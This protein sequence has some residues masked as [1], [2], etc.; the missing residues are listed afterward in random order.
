MKLLSLAAPRLLRK[1]CGVGEA[2]ELVGIIADVQ[3]GNHRRFGGSAEGGVNARARMIL[4]VLAR[5]LD[6]A[7][8]VRCACVVVAG[9]LFD[10]ARPEAALLAAVQRLFSQARE[11]GTRIVVLRGNHDM[12]SD[13]A[14]DNAQ[15]PLAGHASVVAKPTV[16]LVERAMGD[17]VALLLLPYS[18]AQREAGWLAPAVTQLADVAGDVAPQASRLLVMHAGIVGATTPPWLASTPGAVRYEE[19]RVLMDAHAIDACVA[20][21]WHGRRV[22]ARDGATPPYYDVLQV[23]ALVPTGWDNP[24]NRGRY[25][26]IAF[27]SGHGLQWEELGGPRF[28]K[29]STRAEA[30][31]AV[32]AAWAEDRLFVQLPSLAAERDANLQWLAAALERGDIVGGEAPP[33]E[34]EAQVE[35]RAAAGSARAAETFDAALAG[36]VGEMTVDDGVQRERIIDRCRGYLAGGGG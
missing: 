18:P 28:I 4:D 3:L 30:A 36:F 33:D 31:A 34:R 14:D 16:K 35:A 12:A 6:R 23:G 2:R 24:G 13:A 29:C 19:L 20:G 8:E 5:A 25:G 11:R 10:Y 26:T 9:D 17:A 7:V 1:G 21:D 32:E 22:W 15:A 27:W